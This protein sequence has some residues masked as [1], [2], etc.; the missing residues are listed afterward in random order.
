VLLIRGGTVRAPRRRAPCRRPDRLSR[1]SEV[2]QA[3]DDIAQRLRDHGLDVEGFVVQEMEAGGVEMLVGVAHDPSLRAGGLPSVRAVRPSNFS[4]TWPFGS[5]RSAISTHA[6]WSARS[7][8]SRSSTGSAVRRRGT[9]R[10]S[11]RSS[12]RPSQVPSS[13]GLGRRKHT[14]KDEKLARLSPHTT[15][16]PS[17]GDR[18]A[19]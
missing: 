17:R 8:P 14:L 5:R 10:H 4:V 13:T 11:R 19:Q 12:S 9:S 2:A 18:M 1:P 7:G 6:R 3:A 16:V 15:N